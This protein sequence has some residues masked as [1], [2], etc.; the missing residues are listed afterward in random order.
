MQTFF[1]RFYMQLI[2]KRK[3]I[4]RIPVSYLF[5]MIKSLGCLKRKAKSGRK[6]RRD[7]SGSARLP[8]RRFVCGE[9]IERAEEP[10]GPWTLRWK[11]V[12]LFGASGAKR[13]M[14]RRGR[15]R[16]GAPKATHL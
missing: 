1:S 3:K 9:R 2:E 11:D 10:G 4:E 12:C 14:P 13:R 15:S 7:A 5:P 16:G 8:R 6:A